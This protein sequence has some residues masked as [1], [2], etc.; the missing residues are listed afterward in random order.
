[1]SH[2]PTTSELRT[3]SAD[4]SVEDWALAVRQAYSDHLDAA[5]AVHTRAAEEGRELRADERRKVDAHEDELR[6][7][8][9]LEERM[10]RDH[11]G[12]GRVDRSGVVPPQANRGD[13][14]V[15]L[16]RSADRLADWQS[17]RPSAGDE[18]PRFGALIRSWVTGRRDGLTD[19]EHRAMAE[20][21]A[22]AGGAL[23]P[24]PSAARFIDKARNATRV[25]QAGAT[26][27]PMDSNT[28]R[29]P[30]LTGS[31][32]PAWRAENAAIAQG[33]LTFDS[34]TLTAHSLAFLVKL[35][36]ELIEDSDPSA[37]MIVENDLA[38]QVALE[39]DRVALRGSGSGDEPRGVRNTSGVTTTAFG[40]ANGATPTNYDLLI[41]AE[42]AVRA[43]NFEPTGTILSSRSQA[44]LRK[45][46][47]T[48]TGAYLV[49][50]VGL[51]PQYVTNQLPG[52]LV[53]GTSSDTTEIYTGQWPLLYLGM[54]TGPLFIELD[55]RYMDTGQI[56]VVIWYRGDVAVAQPG[57]FAVTTGVR[58]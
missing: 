19:S 34:V 6:R 26:T 1:M 45:M 48:S 55:Q 41:D 25:I 22:S 21:T 30:R 40:G 43:A 8:G 10:K 33:D 7:L 46:K 47:E 9:L 32:A 49:P 17:V 14:D 3:R 2:I 36:R 57:A 35:S 58:P 13:Q 51:V 53:A 15:P 11:P 27:V 29:V 4:Q 37:L 50:P 12:L 18:V 24:A 5:E 56:G 28:L 42:Q 54:R 20:G 16:L 52:N 39:I 31:S 23:V 44:S 38:A